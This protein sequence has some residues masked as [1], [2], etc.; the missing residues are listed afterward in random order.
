MALCSGCC[1]VG[2][3]SHSFI[4]VESCVDLSSGRVFLYSN[5]VVFRFVLW[6]VFHI[7][8]F[9]LNLV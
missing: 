8:L 2:C 4:C 5:D 6:D 9:V 7:H 3:V 1:V